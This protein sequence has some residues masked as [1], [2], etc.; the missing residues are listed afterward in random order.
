MNC[1]TKTKNP[2][3][4]CD[5]NTAIPHS[6]ESASKKGIAYKKNHYLAIRCVFFSKRSIR[7]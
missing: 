7:I 3:P 5:L 1:K 6:F 4:F 2:K